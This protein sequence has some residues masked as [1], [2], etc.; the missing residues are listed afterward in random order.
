M[1]VRVPDGWTIEDRGVYVLVSSP[2]P[3]CYG[4]TLD[5]RSHGVRHDNWKQVIVD[6]AIAHIRAQLAAHGKEQP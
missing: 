6:D 4:A 5:F 2:P 1:N 3:H